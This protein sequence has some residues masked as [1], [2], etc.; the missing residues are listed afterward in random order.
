MDKILDEFCS[1]ATAPVQNVQFRKFGTY[2]L[3]R[4]EVVTQEIKSGFNNVTKTSNDAVEKLNDKINVLSQKMS[5]LTPK[6]EKLDQ[7]IKKIYLALG[8]ILNLQMNETETISSLGEGDIDNSVNDGNIMDV[9]NT[10]INENIY[11]VQSEVS[12]G[13]GGFINMFQMSNYL[14]M[15]LEDYHVA[16]DMTFEDWSRKLEDSLLALDVTTEDK[17]IAMLKLKLAGWARDSFERLPAGHKETFEDAINALKN[18]FDTPQANQTAV[19]KLKILPKMRENESILSYVEKLQKLIVRAYGD[20]GN[21]MVE[22][23]L[24]EEFLDRLPASLAFYVREKSPANFEE[25]LNHA[26]KM[27]ALLQ[28]YD[29][30]PEINT[31]E[32]INELKNAFSLNNRSQNPSPKSPRCSNCQKRGHIAKFCWYNNQNHGQYQQNSAPQNLR[33]K[34]T[35]HNNRSNKGQNINVALNDNNSRIEELEKEVAALRAVNERLGKQWEEHEK[36]A[37][38]TYLESNNSE[39]VND[40]SGNI[41]TKRRWEKEEVDDYNKR[42]SI[43]SVSSFNR[44]IGKAFFL[45]L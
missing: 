27:S 26:R 32:I 29:R 12:P 8:K 45:F 40:K 33:H 39:I 38:F 7:D 15:A 42:K 5:S 13:V 43:K 4:L 34:S 3:D 2:I 10:S 16:M 19:A 25:A 31:Q 24:L 1:I 44:L 28:M 20:K 30:K 22:A 18:V 36:H 14:T 23:K 41:G 11:S 21:Y 35:N 9:V 37:N 17:K 6:I